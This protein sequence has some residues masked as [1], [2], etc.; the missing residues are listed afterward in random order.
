[1]RLLR[2]MVLIVFF[3]LV[4]VLSVHSLNSINQDIGRH[5]KSGQIIWETGRVYKTN[6]FRLP[7]QTTRSSIT[8]G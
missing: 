4:A 6:F 7:N 5:L 1:M 3:V 2:W 8:T